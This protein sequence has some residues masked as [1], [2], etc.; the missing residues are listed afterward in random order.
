MILSR[1]TFCLTLLVMLSALSPLGAAA[2][3]ADNYTLA[4]AWWLQS[5]PGQFSPFYPWWAQPLPGQFSGESYYPS[6]LDVAAGPDG[7]FYIADTVNCRIQ[8]FAPDGAFLRQWGRI[9]S[10]AG[11]LWY[12]TQLAV[13]ADGR[14]YVLDRGNYRVQ[15]YSAT[16]E[17]L[18]SWGGYGDGDSEFRDLAG[19]AVAPDG[20]VYVLCGY[21]AYRQYEIRAYS[22]GGEFLRQWGE[23]GSGGGQLWEP[24]ALAVDGDGNI[25]VT[26]K[27]NQRIQVF[28]STGQYLRQWGEAGS[29]EGHLA[30]PEGLTIGPDGNVYVADTQNQRIQVFTPTGQFLGKWGQIG[31]AD[32][33]LSFPREIA[34]ASG[35]QVCVVDIRLPPLY[36]RICV[37]SSGGGFLRLLGSVGVR[38][39]QLGGPQ[40]VAVGPDGNVYVADAGNYR[41][42]VFS[43]AGAFLR[44]WG[45]QGRGDRQFLRLSGIAVGRDGRVYAADHG[46]NDIQIFDPQGALLGKWDVYGYPFANPRRVTIA[47]DGNIHI[48]CSSAQVWTIA[49]D[50]TLLDVW[51]RPGGAEGELE[52]P[53]GLAARADGNL[54]IA[55]AGNNRLQLLTPTGG[56]LG[57]WGAR[58]S[59]L[60][61]QPQGVAVGR[62]GRV[63]VADTGLG[64]IELF[65]AAMSWLGRLGSRGPEEDQFCGPGDVA[66]APDGTVY[67]ADTVNNRIL[68]YRRTMRAVALPLILRLR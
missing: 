30:W 50:G 4:A 20:T 19:I 36:P 37:Y 3:G 2:Q 11:E 10:G 32:G 52:D 15:G 21:Y 24:S 43:P 47:P 64:R 39:G 12:P 22:P 1:K 28:N 35:G 33:E 51:K 8:V 26:D 25:Y 59:N 40:A 49:P 41:V 13:G 44:G 58:A 60:F 62:D 54:F 23:Y 45:S 34:V 9:G 27:R 6:A 67:I 14:V 66:V 56:F 63:F 53:Y 46:R 7:N 18:A 55:D 5:P 65:D 61:S 68:V 48:T 29:A 17:L 16:G 38:D 42:Q 57:V 31:T